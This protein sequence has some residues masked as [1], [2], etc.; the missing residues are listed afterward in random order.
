MYQN[1]I[2]KSLI[3]VKAL[4][5]RY[6]LELAHQNINMFRGATSA[7][8]GCPNN[9]FHNHQK[10]GQVIYQYPLIQ[11][12]VIRNKA[13]MLCIEDG[14]DAASE[15]IKIFDGKLKI[16]STITKVGIESIDYEEIDTIID[17]SE[18]TY[19]I[20]KWIPFN[21]KNYLVYRNCTG[22][23]EQI[24]LLEKILLGNIL[25]MLKGLD[26]YISEEIYTTIIDVKEPRLT[27]YKGT[28]L[29][30]FD[31]TFKSNV[32]LLNLIG[33]GKHVSV[34]YGVIEKQLDSNYE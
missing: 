16:G 28:R 24:L 4:R 20:R 21:S 13:E 7:S 3:E 32:H 30:S 18:H 6:N 25:S 2:Q 5:I 1:Q 17:G 23:A 11:Y 14:I 31:L 15:F 26:I 22:L 12:K 29:L 19:F 27:K 33:L 8:L 10:D 34:G 9:L